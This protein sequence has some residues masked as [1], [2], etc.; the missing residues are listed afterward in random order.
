M[1]IAE[2]FSEK[3]LF[4]FEK[5]RHGKYVDANEN[6][7]FAAGLDSKIQIIGKYDDDLFWKKQAKIFQRG[8][9]NVI[10]GRLMINQLELQQQS[11]KI[12]SI[13]TTKLP[14]KNKEGVFGSFIDLTDLIFIKKEG[15]FD[16]KL[17]KFYL[18][19]SFGDAYFTTKEMEIFKLLLLGYS[20]KMIARKL[21]ITQSTS[22]WHTSNIILK[23]QCKSKKYLIETAVKNG[24]SHV[25]YS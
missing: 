15:S 10:R 9:A 11:C 16:K 18:G 6:F 24:L 21:D 19:K 5:D 23:L 17:K 22:D 7:V 2:L 4:V 8:D 3:N 20:S 25:I 13:L 14:K 12:A 1:M